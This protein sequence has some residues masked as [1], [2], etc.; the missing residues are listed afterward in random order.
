[1]NAFTREVGRGEEP[2]PC[3]FRALHLYFDIEVLEEARR[4]RRFESLEYRPTPIAE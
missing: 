3:I 1:M 2:L 4:E